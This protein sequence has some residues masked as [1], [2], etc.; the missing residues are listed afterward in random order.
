MRSLRSLGAVLLA[1]MLSLTSVTLAVAR[2]QAPAA[3]QI[4]VC[5]GL[6][7]QTITVDADGKPVGPPHVCPDGVASFIN[8][9]MPVPEM[10]LRALGNGERLRV[11][12]HL[13]SANAEQLRATARGPPVFV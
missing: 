9:D 10:P 12:E 1:V 8:I 4:E 5:S 7:L 11:P 3:G 13:S 6:G 2:G